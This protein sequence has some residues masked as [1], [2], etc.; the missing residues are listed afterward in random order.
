MPYLIQ[1]FFHFRDRFSLKE[2]VNVEAKVDP[3]K[4]TRFLL[5]LVRLHGEKKNILLA[6]IIIEQLIYPFQLSS[7]LRVQIRYYYSTKL[8]SKLLSY[9]YVREQ[10]FLL[11]DLELTVINA[12]AAATLLE[13]RPEKKIQAEW[14]LNFFQVS[15][16]AVL[17][18]HLH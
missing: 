7:Y 3:K 2:I 15:V 18:L 1:H 12:S 13:Q 17:W 11:I 9:F 5:E 10:I 8:K 4:G 16:L 14:S 6:I